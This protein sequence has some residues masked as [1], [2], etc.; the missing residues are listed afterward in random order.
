MKRVLTISDS[1]GRL[2]KRIIQVSYVYAILL[3]SFVWL[4]NSG[5]PKGFAIISL[6]V[7]LFF[8]WG[9]CC[10][11]G[12]FKLRDRIKLFYEKREYSIILVVSFG[13]ILLALVEEAI[14]TLMTNLA[15]FFGFSTSEVFITASPNY[16][17]V[18]TRHS[19]IVFVPWIIVWGF[20]LA[21]Y[22]I[23]PNDVFILFGI[24]GLLAESFTFG[25]Q[26]LIQFGFWIVIYGLM[27]YVPAY[28][29][30]SPKSRKGIM[31]RYYPLLIILPFVAL[32]VWAGIFSLVL[33]VLG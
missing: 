5:N 2:S 14:A 21:R 11:F 8:L 6:A 4:L 13:G 3:T 24:T 33:L 15:P 9:I 29:V 7:G 1:E 25:F 32:L 30:Y 31:K 18:V 19:V 10:S 16:I 27:I 23:H 17:E 22:S 28:I 26:D 20:I 12:M